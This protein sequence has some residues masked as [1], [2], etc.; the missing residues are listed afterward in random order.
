[1]SDPKDLSQQRQE[2]LELEQ[3]CW[4]F[5][6]WCHPEQNSVTPLSSAGS[7]DDSDSSEDDEAEEV[8]GVEGSES[9]A[10]STSTPYNNKYML[11][12]SSIAQTFA[13]CSQG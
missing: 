12:L 5:S 8:N 9:P 2:V 1:M 3:E 11:E 13:L 4:N 7:V 10:I 6:E